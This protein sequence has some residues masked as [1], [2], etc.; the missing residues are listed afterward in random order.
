[1]Q[2]RMAAVMLIMGVM[3]VGC[4]NAQDVVEP[5][6]LSGAEA[7]ADRYSTPG[8]SWGH[9][10]PAPQ[11]IDGD[12]ESTWSS[13]G[14]DLSEVPANLFVTLA[15]PVEVGRMDVIIP[16]HPTPETHPMRIVDM[17]IYGHVGDGWALLGEIRGNDQQPLIVVDLVPSR[18]EQLRLR[19]LPRSET[20][21]AWAMINEIKLYAPAA[22]VELV[23]LQAAEV[24]ETEAEKIWVREALGL[25]PD[26]P[27]VT[28]D[29]EKGYLGYVRT[30]FETM[31]EY[32]T[33]RYGE[34]HSPMF[35][36]VLEIDSRTHPN[37]ELP[38][39]HGQRI[40]DRATYGGNLQ[41]D[42]MAIMA[43]HH[44]SEITGDQRYR[45]IARDYLQ[46]FLDNCTD[47]PTG[48]WPW[49]EHAYWNFYTEG[50]GHTTHHLLCSPLE[51][52]ELAY[53]MNPEAVIREADG[54]INHIR[55]LDTFVYNR[56]ANI[57]TP[58]AVPRP[59][60]LTETDTCDFA[61]SGSRFLRVWSFAYSKT[62]DE[63]YLEWC[64]NLIDHLE[65]SRIG[66]DGPLPVLSNR[67]HR[68]LP[69]RPS[70]DNTMLNGLSMLEYAPLLGDTETA[71]R[72]RSVGQ[73]Y[74][75]LVATQE[76]PDPSREP[77]FHA[78]RGMGGGK[79][80]W[81]QVYRVTG[82]EYFLNA[83]RN[84]ALPYLNL[85]EIPEDTWAKMKAQSF[86]VPID[87]MMDMYELEGDAKWL[88]AAERYARLAIETLYYN[89]LFRAAPDLFYQDAHTGTATIIYA[90]VRVHAAVEDLEVDVPP[91]VYGF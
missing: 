75:D 30:W 21:T 73:E 87:L 14:Q 4:A 11:I 53:E 42:V 43:A 88:E 79:A 60:N 86:G 58:L 47:T 50:L 6:D 84:I 52:W 59:E 37:M 16:I 19:I 85:E 20:V 28:F 12:E 8:G 29:P 23:E 62:G 17:E 70:W 45:Q 71:E 90:L 72:F 25:R 31:A 61:N 2:I 49:G 35:C 18:V 91:N 41:H 13:G 56:H 10:G 48:L 7:F 81:A 34:V 68:P 65:W 76:L 39:V 32:G 54:I 63:K 55:D 33:D 89:G 15:E 36:G 67:S 80:H 74:I 77:V 27:N 44:V 24:P 5:I 82:N 9:A 69:D 64:N 78:G 57:V 3:M 83:A 51:F 26:A 46:Y 38:T 66:G 22:G 1:M 40:S